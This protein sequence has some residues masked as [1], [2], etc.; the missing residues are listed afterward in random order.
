MFFSGVVSL[1]KDEKQHSKKLQLLQWYMA[2]AMAHYGKETVLFLRHIIL[3][4]Q[5]DQ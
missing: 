4:T 1:M 2:E 3:S 5:A